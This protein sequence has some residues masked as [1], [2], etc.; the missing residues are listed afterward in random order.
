MNKIQSSRIITADAGKVF[1]RI[2][3]GHVMGDRIH[4]GIDYS[5]GRARVDDARH[6]EQIDDPDPAEDIET[7]LQRDESITLT[8]EE[9]Q[10][11]RGLLEAAR[12]REGQ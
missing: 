5:T 8:V 1:R 7:R 12:G 3:D 9:V 11:L 4:L 10:A 2:H 6:Y